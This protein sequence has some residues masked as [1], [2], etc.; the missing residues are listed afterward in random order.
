MMTDKER[1]IKNLITFLKKSYKSRKVIPEVE[2][3]Y[4]RAALKIMDIIEQSGYRLSVLLPLEL[5]RKCIGIE[6][7]E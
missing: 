4:S 1:A 2:S 5:N 7:E 6:I 3:Y